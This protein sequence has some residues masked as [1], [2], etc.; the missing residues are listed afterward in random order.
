[1]SVVIAGMAAMGL[2]AVAGPASAA[3]GDAGY[4]DQSY[5]GA[6]YAPTSDKPQ[7][8]LWYAQGSWWAD[9]FDTVSRTWHVFRLDRSTQAWTDTGVRID[10]RPNSLADVLWDGTHLYVASHVVTVSSDSATRPSVS[11]SPARL[12]RY[13][14]SAA[15][16]KYTLDQG[17]PVAITDSS[18]ESL[19]IDKDSTGTL[20]ATWT[21]VSGSAAAG[22]TSAVYVNA[23]TGS[24][25]SWGTPFALPT[26][27]AAV[28][29]DDISTV[30]A[31]GRSKV[32]VMWSNELDGGVYWAVHDDGAA[33][34]SWKV[35]P[36]VRGNKQADDHLNIKVVEA[37]T[38]GRV[39]AVVKTS[40]DGSGTAVATDPQIRLLNFKPATGSWTASTVG[41]LADCHTRPQLVL[42]EQNRTVHV[43]ATAP[44]S[45]GCP[46]PGAPG[47]IY[48][49]T[50]SM[51]DPVFATG[52]GTPVIRDVASANMN[53]VT[54]T[55]QSVTPASGLVVLASNQAT[56]RYWHADIAL[57]GS[58][59]SPPA[60]VVPT[61]SFGASVTGGQAPLPVQF[62]DTSSG[63]P[64]SWAWDFGDGATAATQ[65]PSH[66]FSAAGSY[67]VRL[68]A[69]NAAG[70]SAAATAT[71]TVTAAPVT[72]GPG[73]GG[74]QVSVGAS[75]T[76][77]S[78]TAVDTVVVPR[79]AGVR[80][81]DVLIAQITADGAPAV[82]PLP[83]GWS[84]VLTGPLSLGGNARVA[85]YVH[86][87]GDL[88]AE[89]AGYRWGLSTPV[90]WNA[91]IT[92]FSGVD[93]ADPFDT[94]V[95]TAVNTGYSS[96]SL[97][98]PGVGTGTA[99]SVLV[100]GVGLDSSAAGVT[101]PTGWTE[102]AEAGGAQTAELA[103]RAMPTAGAS[104]SATWTL[105]KATA[106][107]GWITALRP[108]A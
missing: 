73:A 82:G 12:Y 105:P 72:G 59:P 26:A 90:K 30:V 78:T 91:G 64:T 8:K 104:G 99:G 2:G 67:T 87:V 62:Q 16:Q 36:A 42:D 15:T 45:G 17:F 71:V 107:A 49:K 5:T 70:S 81:G 29:P 51:D 89:P 80:A 24:D 69:A 77:G 93:P 57:P 54:T 40:L 60:A 18:S 27:E 97:T 83:A 48:E 65:H 39:F 43:F 35:S 22:Y 46:Y 6:T 14:W 4:Q 79:P 63:S 34:G 3:A 38:S 21:Q 98:V 44:T 102:S 1:V 13:S 106:A 101:A 28:S 25:S 61:A 100:G 68:V 75:S 41:T 94:A 7:S 19:T 53:D 88:A 52:R 76:A 103:Y 108:A 47:T 56:K 55:K 11:G 9:M 95:S 50:A 86:V 92:A 33:R 96:S 23:T 74:G 66:T 10:D 84:A 20:W 32:G 31:F 85:A 37:D 58:P